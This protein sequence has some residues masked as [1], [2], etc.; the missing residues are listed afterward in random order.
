MEESGLM[1]FIHSISHNTSDAVLSILALIFLVGA[2]YGYLAY[3]GEHYESALK[4]Q[5][6]RFYLSCDNSLILAWLYVETYNRCEK[7]PNMISFM[8]YLNYIYAAVTVIH[9]IVCIYLSHKNH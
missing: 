3:T 5:F 1:E 9:F 6:K 4:R 2:V 8:L 7:S